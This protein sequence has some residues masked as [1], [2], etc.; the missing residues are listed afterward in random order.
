LGDAL[1]LHR[2]GVGYLHSA[3]S[4]Q[5]L[6]GLHIIQVGVGEGLHDLGYGPVVVVAGV[7]GDGRLAG[8]FFGGIGE[9]TE[10]IGHGLRII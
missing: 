1:L 8:E 10:F 9:G 4:L 5:I 3:Q 6:G 7:G 2:F